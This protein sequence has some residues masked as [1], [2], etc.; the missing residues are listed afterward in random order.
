MLMTLLPL[1]SLAITVSST[2]TSTVTSTVD[3]PV[4]VAVAAAPEIVTSPRVAQ[5]RL[6]ETLA[7]AESIESITARVT[8]RGRQVTFAIVH[9]GDTLDVIA[10]TGKRGDIVALTIKPA[11]PIAA[12]LHG[13]TWLGAELAQSTAVTR[14]AV[15]EDGAV[16]ITTS[17][18]QRYMAIPGRGSG[19]ANIAVEARW[20][21]TWSATDS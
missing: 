14:L 7:S 8:P 5:V 20:A 10:T 12:Q 4:D 3:V 13:L 1:V 19:G 18:G 11:T 6:A 15:H 21:A 2:V 16:T 17:E 9:D